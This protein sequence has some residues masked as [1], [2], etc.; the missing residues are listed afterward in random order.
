MS[1]Q[2]PNTII[3]LPFPPS[4]TVSDIVNRRKPSRAK[5]KSP[6]AF[7]IYR[8]AFLNQ[9]SR[10]HHNLRMTDVSRLVSKYWQSETEDVK[11]AYRKI[12]QEVENELSE[13][14]KKADSYRV[15][16]KNSKY[17]AR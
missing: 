1:C 10:S 17:S 8:K 3:T 9:L 2:N 16:W 5:S 11:D 7:L 14:R 13:E 6:N 4:I 12:A 15:V